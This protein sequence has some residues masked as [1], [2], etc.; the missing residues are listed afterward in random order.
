MEVELKLLI[1]AKFKD[2]LLRHPL[3]NG[4]AAKPH[5]HTLSDTYFDTPDLRLRDRHVGL[6]VRRVDGGWVQ[7]IRSGDD[8]RGGVH[9]RHEW[10]SPVAG[11]A[12]E[13]ARLREVVDDKKT[14]REVLAAAA[15]GKGLAP[16]FTS[17]VKRTEWQRD[18]VQIVCTLDQRRLESGGKKTPIG[19]LELALKSGNPARLFDLALALQKDLPLHIGS[20]SKPDRGY[21]LF[22][23]QVPAAVKATALVLTRRMSTEQAFQ[24]IAF[25]CLSHMQDNDQGVAVRHD[26]ESLHQ[27]RVGMR[28]LRSALAMFKDVLQLPEDMQSELDWLAQQLGAARDWD[29]LAGVTLPGIARRL[30]DPAPLDAAIVGAA[31]RAQQHHVAA[32]AALAEARYTRLMLSIARWLQTMGWRDQPAAQPA[33]RTRLTAPVARFARRTLQ[34][35]QRRLRARAARLGEATP[36]ARHRVR[37]AAKKTRYAAEF[38]ASLFAQK[39]VRPY[40]KALTGLQDELGYLNDAAVADRLLAELA[41]GEAQLDASVGFARGYLAAR[42]QN[43]DKAILKLWKRCARIGTPR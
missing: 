41:P 28:R 8:T 42:I 32:A 18:G 10:E 17:K 22:A 19:E 33:G 20:R 16:I 43:D 6:R 12:P 7:N 27:M 40:V 9:S 31:D 38:F 39:T 34:R 23:A 4:H 1:D 35:D 2:A 37:I 29:V 30:A 13:L 25:N 14:R 21:A 26:V 15:M 11:P 24:A 36:A 3:L 5:E